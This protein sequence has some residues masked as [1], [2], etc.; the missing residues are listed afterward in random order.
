MDQ[1]RM[2]M[3]VRHFSPKTQEAYI[4]WILKFILFHNKRHPLDMGDDEIRKFL[5]YLADRRN[6]SS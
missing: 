6:V 4:H 2:A 5:T 1:V 3:I